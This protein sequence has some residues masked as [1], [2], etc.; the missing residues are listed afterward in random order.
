MYPTSVVGTYSPPSKGSLAAPKAPHGSRRK[1]KK[2][3]EAAQRVVG[4]GAMVEYYLLWLLRW[5][6]IL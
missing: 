2:R 6:G 1:L 3:D 4:I 5:P